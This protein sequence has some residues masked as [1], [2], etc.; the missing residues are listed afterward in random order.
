MIKRLLIMSVT[1]LLLMTSHANA[2]SLRCGSKIISVGALESEVLNWCGPPT[3]EDS[4][5]E[6]RLVN[7]NVY[8]F[9]SSQKFPS[10]QA[11]IAVVV[12][13]AV[14]QWT[15]NNGPTQFIR[16]LTFERGRLVNIK[17]GDYGY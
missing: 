7:P 15:Y 8:P 17:T 4:W 13:V 16:I 14:D 1:F 5:V 6:D 2:V 11:P 10:N 3:W 12:H 9:S